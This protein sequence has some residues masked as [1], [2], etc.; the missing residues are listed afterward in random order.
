MF[1][2]FEKQQHLS[3]RY[4]TYHYFYPSQNQINQT[5]RLC[6]FEQWPGCFWYH[7]GRPE[8][9]VILNALIIGK[10]QTQS[11]RHT[12]KHSWIGGFLYWLNY[13]INDDYLG[14]YGGIQ[15]VAFGDKT[16]IFAK[17]TWINARIRIQ[18]STCRSGSQ[19]HTKKQIV[20]PKILATRERSLMIK[21][22]FYIFQKLKIDW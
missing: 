1:D 10:E 20:P 14:I 13:D 6:S 5:F 8:I 15:F 9:R 2:L 16:I 11:W 3:W 21:W 17:K 4:Q 7:Q 12:L 18:L 22:L 19:M